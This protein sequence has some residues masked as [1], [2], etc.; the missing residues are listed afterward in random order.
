MKI[1]KWIAASGLLVCLI[2]SPVPAPEQNPEEEEGGCAAGTITVTPD[3]TPPGACGG[4]FNGDRTI[5]ISITPDG[6][7]STSHVGIQNCAVLLTCPLMPTTCPGEEFWVDVHIDRF[8][9]EGVYWGSGFI[10]FDES[11]MTYLGKDSTP[12]YETSSNV[13]HVSYGTLAVDVYSNPTHQDPSN[14][15]LIMTRLKFRRNA[16]SGHIGTSGIRL[17]SNNPTIPLHEIPQENF[18]RYGATFSYAN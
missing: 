9:D 6:T 17:Y 10:T 3:Y 13:T 14:A 15:R 16:L 8:N 18:C 4:E 7:Q 2:F 11:M 5:W 12:D 1:A